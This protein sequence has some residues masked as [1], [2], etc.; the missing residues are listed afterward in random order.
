MA[1]MP[2]CSFGGEHLS[3]GDGHDDD[4]VRPHGRRDASQ[5]PRR[6]VEMLEQL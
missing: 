6:I 1:Y 4:A 2:D 5:R 3:V